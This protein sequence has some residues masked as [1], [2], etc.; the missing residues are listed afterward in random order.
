MIRP[1]PAGALIA[2]CQSTPCVLPSAILSLL[3][4]DHAMQVALI[5]LHDAQPS[6][7]PLARFRAQWAGDASRRARRIRMALREAGHDA[8][9]ERMGLDA[10]GIVAAPVGPAP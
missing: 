1:L 4:E 9:A 5:R 8:A 3:T 2:A 7:D 10:Y 6:T